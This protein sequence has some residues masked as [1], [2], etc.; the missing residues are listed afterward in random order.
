MKKILILIL[1]LLILSVN[2][3]FGIEE[4]DTMNMGSPKYL[5]LKVENNKFILEWLNPIHAMVREGIQYQVDFKVGRNKWQSE[6]GNILANTLDFTTNGKT[7]ITFDPVEEGLIKNINLEEN[8]YNIRIRYKDDDIVS[9][10]SNVVSLGLRPYYENASEWAWSELDMAADLKLIPESIRQDM[11]KVITREEFCEVVIRLYELQTGKTVDY[12]GQSIKD[13][14]NTEVLKAAKLGLVQGNEKGNFLPKDPITR[15]E[16]AIML[17]RMLEVFFPDMDFGYVEEY[18]YADDGD[19]AVWAYDDM[20]Y[21]IHKEILRGDL[22]GKV[23][24]WSH[25]TREEAVVVV[26]RLFNKF[27]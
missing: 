3:A 11:K 10:F 6:E 25:T 18:D 16:I 9:N 5:T 17:R 8:S 1:C 21:M 2:V 4:V 24:P 12:S 20:Q 23:N 13:S 14:T 26:L 19:I 27:N 15:Q 7:S 22:N